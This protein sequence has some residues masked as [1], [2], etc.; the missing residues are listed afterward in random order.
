MKTKVQKT[1]PTRP[2]NNYS[3][4]KYNIVGSEHEFDSDLDKRF[5][6][7][8]WQQL[9]KQQQQQPKKKSPVHYCTIDRRII[10]LDIGS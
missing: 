5:F 6:H 9:Q 4:W 2:K 7:C 8:Y 1:R 10:T 3:D